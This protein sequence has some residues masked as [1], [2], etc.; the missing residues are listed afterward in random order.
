MIIDV[1]SD[2]YWQ[3]QYV[4]CLNG[5]ISEE[6]F[7][8]RA[9]VK[10]NSYAGDLISGVYDSIF[11]RS[12]EMKS[13]YCR[14]YSKEFSSFSLYAQRCHLLT[15]DQSDKLEGLV[16]KY[17]K[18]FLLKAAHYFIQ[19]EYGL[20]FLERLVMTRRRAR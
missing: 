5:S 11:R 6:R 7:L 1:G 18:M 14:Y 15:A 4:I 10:K 3:R 2:R 20:S 16:S 9:V 17:R 13:D 8:H 19:E 12:L